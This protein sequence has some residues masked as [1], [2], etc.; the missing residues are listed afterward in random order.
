[1]S[2]FTDNYL[3]IEVDA[4]ASLDNTIVPVRLERLSDDGEFVYA[5]LVTE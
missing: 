5:T 1:M 3:K 4:P 2:G